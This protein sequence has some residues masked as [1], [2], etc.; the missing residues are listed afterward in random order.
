MVVVVVMIGPLSSSH[1]MESILQLNREGQYENGGGD[2]DDD[3]STDRGL[4]INSLCGV[5][6]AQ[7]CLHTV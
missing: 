4:I 3:D 2:H 5:C 7:H 1:S 6:L